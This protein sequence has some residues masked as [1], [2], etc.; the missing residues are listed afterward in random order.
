MERHLAFALG[1]AHF[2]L[3]AWQDLNQEYLKILGH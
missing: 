3:Q 1:K 2:D